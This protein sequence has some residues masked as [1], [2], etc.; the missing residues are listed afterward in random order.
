M[1]K[2]VLLFL[3]IALSTIK[4]VSQDFSTLLQSKKWY[5]TGHFYEKKNLIATSDNKTNYDWDGEF[6][7]SGKIIWH[8]ITKES[9]FDNEGNEIAPGKE[10]TDKTYSYIVKKNLLQVSRFIPKDDGTP[11]VDVKYYYKIKE[12]KNGL[13]LVPVSAEEFKH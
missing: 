6:L 12:A 9:S 11:A 1:K 13:E 4:V 5:I 2:S 10:V 3:V 8:E 7:S